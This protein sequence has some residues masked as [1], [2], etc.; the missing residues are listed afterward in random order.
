M[1]PTVLLMIALV[2]VT[3]LFAVASYQERQT[4]LSQRAASLV[5]ALTLAVFCSSWTFYGAVGSM[6]SSPW[7]HT[8]IYLGPILLLVLFRPVVSRLVKM[9]HRQK[10][11]SIADFLGARYGKRRAV[12][13][14]VALIC[15]LA[16]LPYLALQFRA[17][18]QIWTVVNTGEVLAPDTSSDNVTL[19]VAVG[20]ALFAILFG[21]RR[22]DGS[23]RQRGLMHAM[24]VES[25]VKL[26]A[27]AGIAVL[28]LQWLGST[29]QGLAAIPS[30][31]SASLN[32]NFA[33]E[34]LVSALAILC[35]PRQFH[36]MVV[37][38]ENI[39]HTR[40]ARWFFPGYLL[41]FLVLAVPI[42]AA[43]A[44]LFAGDATVSADTYVQVLPMALGSGWG[45][46]AAF[47]GGISA[48]TGMVL[49][50]TVSVSIMVTN[51]LVTPLIYRVS[52]ARSR[53][54]L[55]LGSLLRRSRQITVFVISIGAWLLAAG[56]SSLPGLSQIGFLSF[57]GSAQLAPA[58]LLGLY[59]QRAHGVAVL[60][61]M[62]VGAL[63]WLVYGILPLTFLPGERLSTAHLTLLSLGCNTA[64][65][66]VLSWLL[67][68]SAAD[69]RQAD[70]FLNG[71]SAA[72]PLDVT[73]SP[74]PV[75]QLDHLVAPLL[76][77]MG[78]RR[79]W[80]ELETAYGQRL[81]PGDRAPQF[82]VAAAEAVLANAV[83]ATSAR[84]IVRRLASER[85]LELR[86]LT[87]LLGNTQ[88]GYGFNRESLEAA[89]ENLSHGVSVIDADLRLL[90]W[91]SRYEL[92]FDYPPR[93]LFV[94]CPI[95]RVYRF[96]AERGI[97][98]SSSDN[99]DDDVERRLQFMRDGSPHQVERVMPDGRVLDIRGKPIPG[100]G[101]VTTY[102]DITEYRE[103][104]QR[105]TETQQELTQRLV[106]GEQT[107][108]E[109]NARLRDEVRR[110]SEAESQLRTAFTSKAEFM[111]ATSHDLLQPINAARLLAATLRHRLP[112]IANDN[113]ELGALWQQLEVALGRSESMIAELREMARLDAGKQA[114]N[115]E[116]F[117][118][119]SL[120]QELEAEFQSLAAKRGLSFRVMR[121]QA[122]V[123]G[124]RK[125]TLRLLEN[126]LS[127]AVK[128]TDSGR[129]L[130]GVRR[131]AA[132]IQFVVCDTGPGIAEADQA[133][134]FRE[135]ERLDRSRHNDAD[136]LGLGLSLVNRY[137]GLLGTHISLHSVINRGSVFA[138]ELDRAKPPVG[139]DVTTPE[140][141]EG[142]QS[143]GLK[144]A[145]L[146]NDPSLLA[147]ITEVLVGM[148]MSAH[149][150]RT[151]E[152]LLAAI[153]N[154]LGAQCLVIDQQ[155]DDGATGLE[156]ARACSARGWQ[157]P[158]VI[159]SADDSA[160]LRA[161]VR[162]EGFRFMAKPLESHRL[163]ALI[164]ALVNHGH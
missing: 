145:V 38:V 90:A 154:G 57:V 44:L 5:Y 52:M 114:F 78:L 103:M 147:G 20:L 46:A 126:L 80:R 27:F 140:A 15:L 36:V 26:L 6:A 164:E 83:G 22:L 150:Y 47:L 42:S 19:L 138:F 137:A 16:V 127:N 10:V 113:A 125:L 84:Q 14:V 95:E 11:T 87:G 156:T 112:E 41:L 71:E 30:L 24:A 158:V 89:V 130:L 39:G 34:L 105:L 121:T 61:G 117:S 21:V 8:P 151:P 35:L 53:V 94:G 102:V 86:D 161:A 120:F 68:P 106:T 82:V 144:V 116:V 25:V 63:L 141:R 96:N 157:L 17:L 92:M 51:E 142:S 43:G 123:Y 109:R 111:A 91:N 115:P 18:Q 29:P 54:L 13:T 77:D 122:W 1:T 66:V 59:W 131:R 160:Q 134:I 100:G 98:A 37:E 162:D 153:D 32:A 133:R 4:E 28:A 58:L 139:A 67:R 128:Y 31:S 152:D 132:R 159:I 97:L 107:L 23:E 62:L 81:L 2:Y 65:C 49:V 74:I 64:L 55:N 118:V 93:F 60:V 3:G 124:D 88:Q 12:G 45:V 146:D 99:P 76:T 40:M 163:R 70:V 79:F 72:Q 33:A 48:A 85:Q 69:S 129:V 148:G 73:L 135:F 110:R 50:A 143:A 101:F 104:T 119:A 108:S 7:S 136:G 149:G 75:I 155:L 9:G 56:M